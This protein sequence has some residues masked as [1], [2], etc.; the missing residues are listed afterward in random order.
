ML[1]S[2][3][4]APPHRDIPQRRLDDVCGDNAKQVLQDLGVQLEAGLVEG[5]CHHCQHLAQQLQVVRLVELGRK[6]AA[7]KVGQ[8][9]LGSSGQAHMLLAAMQGRP[10]TFTIV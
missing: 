4:G 7:G 10:I 2:H 8:H 6:F 1:L 9:V 3:A 5:V